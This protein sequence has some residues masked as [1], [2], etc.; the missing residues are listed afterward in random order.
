MSSPNVP[1]L[2]GP[3]LQNIQS[4]YLFMYLLHRIRTSGTLLNATTVVM[5]DGHGCHLMPSTPFTPWSTGIS[6]RS[7]I[8]EHHAHVRGHY[9]NAPRAPTLRMDKQSTRTSSKAQRTINQPLN[10]WPNHTRH[11]THDE[12]KHGLINYRD[13]TATMIKLYIMNRVLT[14]RIQSHTESRGSLNDFE[15]DLIR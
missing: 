5:P 10:T 4:R 13:S 1:G 15:D 6:T 9:S 12:H 7:R 14:E 11:T 2:T 8:P 3:T